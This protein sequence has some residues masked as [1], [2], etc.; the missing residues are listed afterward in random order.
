MILIDLLPELIL[1]IMDYLEIKHC[2]NVGLVNQY[3]YS[4]Y[5][6]K[7]NMLVYNFLKKLFY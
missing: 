2:V 7:I 5:K 3:L 1:E 4:I 6:K